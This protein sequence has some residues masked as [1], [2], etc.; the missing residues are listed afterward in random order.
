MIDCLDLLIKSDTIFLKLASREPKTG[1]ECYKLL[2]IGGF[3]DRLD[4]L[5][6]Y[7][8]SNFDG[9]HHTLDGCYVFEKDVYRL[10][11]SRAR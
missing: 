5:G 4:V 9:I 8:S 1:L 10:L 6:A 3:D 11:R 7:R 2:K